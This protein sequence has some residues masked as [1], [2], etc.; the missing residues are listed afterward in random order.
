MPE[1]E[2]GVDGY[3]TTLGETVQNPRLLRA[4]HD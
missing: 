2:P 4:R 1:K 3:L